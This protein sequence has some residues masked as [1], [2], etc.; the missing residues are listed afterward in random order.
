SVRRHVGAG[1]I[2]PT[3]A[4]LAQQAL[5]QP[6]DGSTAA[7]GAREEVESGRVVVALGP[8]EAVPGAFVPPRNGPGARRVAG[9]VDRGAD[10]VRTDRAETLGRIGDPG[11]TGR[12]LERLFRRLAA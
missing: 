4:H 6:A 8:A 9:G 2:A 7:D 5:Q 1:C 12:Q 3:R 11:P 10:G